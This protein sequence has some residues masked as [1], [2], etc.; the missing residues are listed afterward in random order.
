M[1]IIKLRNDF[2][3]DLVDSSGDDQMICRAARVSTLGAD[4]IDTEESEG[5]L[6]F[7]MSNRHGSPFEHGMMTFRITAPIFVWREFMR[8]RIGFS[9]NEES[10]R[11]KKLEPVFYIPG[12]ERPLIQMGKPGAYHFVKGS[13]ED[14]RLTETHLIEAYDVAWKNYE[15]ML[16]NEIAKEVARM[17][18]PVSIYS[19]AY[20]TC[21]PRSVMSFLSLRTKD[22]R[23]KF[24][25]SPMWEINDVADQM[26]DIFADIWPITHRLFRKH[27]AVSP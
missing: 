19:T 15:A 18:L 11:Y 25:S 22:A 4:S 3:V 6:N 14:L 7:L 27:G 8:H 1:T 23:S 2:D 5:L 24:P 20:V 12:M 13:M 26:E 9:Y 10:G 16:E 17:C 21:N